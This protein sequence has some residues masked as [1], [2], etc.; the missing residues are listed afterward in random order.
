MLRDVF[1]RWSRE[2][3]DDSNRKANQIFSFLLNLHL[4]DNS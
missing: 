4:V 1:Q 2:A 3:G